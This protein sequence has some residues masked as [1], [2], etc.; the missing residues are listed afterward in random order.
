MVISNGRMVI[1]LKTTYDETFAHLSPGLLL[2]QELIRDSFAR[3]PGG[4]FEFYTNTHASPLQLAW[5]TDQR[6][7]EHVSI[8]RNGA[9]HQLSS[10]LQAAKG[11]AARLGALGRGLRPAPAERLE[12][13]TTQATP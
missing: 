10:A 11:M 12:P 4:V 1:Y 13:G 5:A 6:W 7:I 9:V 8:Y 3:L 2:L